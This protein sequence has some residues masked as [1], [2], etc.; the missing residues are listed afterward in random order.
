MLT[1]F[2]SPLVVIFFFFLRALTILEGTEQVQVDWKE[3]VS[4]YHH[5]CYLLKVWD[6]HSYWPLVVLER[7]YHHQFQWLPLSPACI[8]RVLLIPC[9]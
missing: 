9:L 6:S 4:L 8:R 2:F 5:G 1:L 3:H 7:E